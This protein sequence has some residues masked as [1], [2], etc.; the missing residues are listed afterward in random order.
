MD[1]GLVVYACEI[2]AFVCCDPELAKQH[3]TESNRHV[4]SPQWRHSV[5][6]WP[7]S[8]SEGSK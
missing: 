7:R 1:F 2:C 6:P 4:P 3:E 5:R 8:Q